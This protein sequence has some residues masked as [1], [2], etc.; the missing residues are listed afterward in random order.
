LPGGWP[1]SERLWCFYLLLISSGIS[2]DGLPDCGN[3]LEVFES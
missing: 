3:H 2:Q 1:P